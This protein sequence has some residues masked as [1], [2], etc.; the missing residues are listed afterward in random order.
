MLTYSEAMSQRPVDIEVNLR[1]P[2]LTIKSTGPEPSKVINNSSN[3]F[4]KMMTVPAVPKAGDPLR[5]TVGADTTLDCNVTRVE[6]ND[7][8]ALFIVSCSLAGRGIPAVDYQS[9]INDPVWTLTQLP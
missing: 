3:R 1:V 9:L 8:R 5:V 6:W 7:D 2:S 4:R